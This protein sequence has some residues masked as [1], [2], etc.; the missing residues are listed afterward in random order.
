MIVTNDQTNSSDLTPSIITGLLLFFIYPI[1]L[2]VM[3]VWPKWNKWIKIALTI[4]PIVFVTA[5]VLSF[6]YINPI[7]ERNLAPLQECVKS[8]NSTDV[9]NLC[10]RK[11]QENF[12]LERQGN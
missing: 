1:G 5:I 12:L 6:P 9:T 4:I 10:I 2:L 11:C 3:W 8:C 7:T